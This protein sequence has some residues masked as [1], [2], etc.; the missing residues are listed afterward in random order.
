MNALRML[1]A[2]IVLA[3]A[4]CSATLFGQTPYGGQIQEGNS[5][6]GAPANQDLNFQDIQLH[7][8]VTRPDAQQLQAKSNQLAQQYVKAEGEEKKREI[9][10]ELAD[11]LSQ[12]FD[13]HIK[14][15][16]KEVDDLEKQIARLKSVLRKRLDAKS[17]IVER[18]LEQMVQDAEGLGWNAPGNPQ[19]PFGN[20][21]QSVDF[22]PPSKR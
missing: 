5:S 15:Q 8:T 16:Q 2:G 10:K 20:Y 21:P 11:V 9:R 18:R 7:W 12:Q 22:I 17:T 6:Y 1:T 13:L 3:G 14:Q 19:S 4:I